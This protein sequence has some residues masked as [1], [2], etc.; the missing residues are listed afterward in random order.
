M[1][2]HDPKLTIRADADE[3]ADAHAAWAKTA[4]GPAVEA[5]AEVRPF[6]TDTGIAIEPLYSPATLAR[7]GFD[8]L[9]DVGFPGAF[10]F[11]RGDR[12]AMNRTEPFVVSAY[13]GFGEAETCNKRLKSLVG[14]GVQQLLLAADL[15]ETQGGLPRPCTQ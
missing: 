8:Y 7:E 12:P 6:V 3:V 13:T 5:H 9:D 14:M 4:Y 15:L 2:T 10:P 1:N 11:T